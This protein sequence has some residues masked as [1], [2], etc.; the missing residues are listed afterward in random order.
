MKRKR[1]VKPEL[2]VENFLVQDCIATCDVNMVI[3]FQAGICE[4]NDYGTLN[5]DAVHILEL[6]G[7]FTDACDT[8]PEGYCYHNMTGDV[9]FNS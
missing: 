5:P 4:G 6:A 2:A 9:I 8:Q 3:I 7:A 1:Y